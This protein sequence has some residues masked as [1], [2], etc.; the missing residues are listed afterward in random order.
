MRKW[1]FLIAFHKNY[2]GHFKMADLIILHFPN[3]DTV[4]CGDIG[5]A[6]AKAIS[7][8]CDGISLEIIPDGEGGI[9]TTLEFSREK[10][11]WI[12]AQ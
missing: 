9:V 7:A 12:S 8:S 1:R 11:D 6:T 4:R 3:G 10:R 2:Q 5:D